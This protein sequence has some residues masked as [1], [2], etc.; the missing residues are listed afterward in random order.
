MNQRTRQN[1]RCQ[2]PLG[3]LG[4]ALLLW[5][6]A[7]ATAGER[8]ASAP[9]PEP[10]VHATM[11]LHEKV[12]PTLHLM[13]RQRLQIRL[14]APE[15]SKARWALAYGRES[16]ASGD[17]LAGPD[18]GGEAAFE[19]PDVRVRAACTLHVRL[20]A[21]RAV[22]RP[23][24]VLPGG[25][26]AA[27]AARLSEL[28]IGLIDPTGGL[29]HA[30]RAEGATCQNLATDLAADVFAGELVVLAGPRLEEACRRLAARIQAGMTLLLINPPE[31]WS[32]WGLAVQK[33]SPAASGP[34]ALAK[35]V[36][37]VLQ[38]GPRALAP[39]P[40]ARRSHHA[41]GLAG[42]VPSPAG[43]GPLGPRPAGH[44]AGGVGAAGR[45]P[46]A[47]VDKPLH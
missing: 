39:V 32:R 7:L 23:I 45:R 6:W 35:G 19:A 22:S 47:A 24:V 41:A 5:P 30:L 14:I 17:V 40:S 9:A 8:Q 33:L 4:A 15:A 13:G 31:G 34:V 18:A 1:E 26:L 43:G 20:A 2:W 11:E 28:R 38:A 10:A 29:A 42:A 25:M 16:L 27:S 37:T 36:C 44:H 12:Q 46:M 21:G 3:P